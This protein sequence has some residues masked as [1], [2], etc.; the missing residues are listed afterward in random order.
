MQY[1]LAQKKSAVTGEDSR[2]KVRL[3]ACQTLDKFWYDKDEKISPT[4]NPDAV[5]CQDNVQ[6]VS[7]I[8]YD[9][10]KERSGRKISP[11]GIS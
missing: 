6:S 1:V 5:N 10:G 3:V 9:H 7:S 11:C 2:K 4:V 8:G